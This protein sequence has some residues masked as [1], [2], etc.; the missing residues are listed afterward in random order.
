MENSMRL[1][2]LNTSMIMGSSGSGRH[3]RSSAST[4]SRKAGS[5]A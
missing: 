5:E 3:P 1:S 4:A 2:C